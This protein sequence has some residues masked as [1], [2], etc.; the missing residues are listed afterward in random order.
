M[1][2]NPKSMDGHLYF[3]KNIILCLKILVFF[4]DEHAVLVLQSAYTSAK[5]VMVK[6]VKGQEVEL[7][8][9]KVIH[10]KNNSI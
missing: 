8:S 7:D 2:L 3:R 5:G 6:N 9:L 4:Q 1:K 10:P